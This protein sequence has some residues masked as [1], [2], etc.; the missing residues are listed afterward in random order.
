MSDQD[1]NEQ[2]SSESEQST[3]DPVEILKNLKSEI[4][5]KLQNSDSRLEQLARQNEM[6]TQA[7][8]GLAR[9]QRSEMSEVDMEEL[10][11]SNPKAYQQILK[12]QIKDEVSKELGSTMQVEQQRQQILGQ[13][14]VDYPELKTGDSDLTQKAV[15]IY[16]SM[17]QSEQAMPSSYK[18]AVRDAAAELG[19][20]PSSKR[21]SGSSEEWTGSGTRGSSS[22][23]S[24]QSKKKTEVDPR[25]L[26]FA[27]M[28]GL[29]V[30]KP[31]VVK[32]IEKRAQRKKWSRYE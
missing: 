6:L 9:P 3:P 19:L 1:N 31:E 4:N 28:V 22:G 15:A 25:T 24:P 7:L 14:V 29:D 18:I 16:N 27:Q 30:S 21:K 2:D 23:T 5:R 17:S 8:Q 32:N 12:K 13:L 10:A 11:V 26:A 20:L